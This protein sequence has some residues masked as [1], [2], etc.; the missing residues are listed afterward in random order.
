M[1][2]MSHHTGTIQHKTSVYSED[3]GLVV[4]ITI[5]K[6]L[7]LDF[8]RKAPSLPAVSHYQGD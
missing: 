4:N 3:N 6:E 1:G 2:E 8:I 7:I 5:T